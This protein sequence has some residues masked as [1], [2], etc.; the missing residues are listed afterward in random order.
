MRTPSHGI[1]VPAAAEFVL[2]GTIDPDA[3]AEEGP[4]GEFTGYS[5]D[6][7]TNNVLRID[8]MMRRRMHGSSTWSAARTQNI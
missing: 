6:R 7:S 4:F 5:S 2:E 8:A 3:H 1:G